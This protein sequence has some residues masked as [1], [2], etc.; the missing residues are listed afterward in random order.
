MW[1]N[2]TVP[3][4]FSAILYALAHINLKVK[5]GSNPIKNCFTTNMTYQTNCFLIWGFLRAIRRIQGYQHIMT[6]RHLITEPTHIQ[7]GNQRWQIPR[8]AIC[9]CLAM[10]FLCSL[11]IDRA[12]QEVPMKK[13]L[14]EIVG[15]VFEIYAIELF[16]SMSTEEAWR[17]LHTLQFYPE[18][19][20]IPGV[21]MQKFVMIHWIL[22]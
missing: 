10:S 2:Q 20:G 14:K 18:Y 6:G 7:H 19:I 11:L 21:C 22:Q 12:A 13:Y 5:C 4:C 8:P 17:H 9:Q 16:S 15:P 3:T 1:N